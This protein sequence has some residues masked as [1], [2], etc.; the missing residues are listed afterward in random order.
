MY[1]YAYI[2]IC[3]YTYIYI[4]AYIYRGQL[5]LTLSSSKFMVEKNDEFALS[6]KWLQENFPD[7]PKKYIYIL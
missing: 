3:T 2:Y 6:L 5:F 7:Y 1:I 4:Y